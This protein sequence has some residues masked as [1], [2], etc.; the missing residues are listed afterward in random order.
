[1]VPNVTCAYK[2]WLE[3][4]ITGDN[5]GDFKFKLEYNIK[6]KLRDVY[7]EDMNSNE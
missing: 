5:M 1:M 7:S 2:F 3:N 4:L 6:L